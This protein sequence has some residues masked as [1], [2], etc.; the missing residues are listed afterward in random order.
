[1]TLKS[2]KK[3]S[4]RN[5]SIEKFT[6]SVVAG[7]KRAGVTPLKAKIQT[8]YDQGLTVRDTIALMTPKKVTRKA[9]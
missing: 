4:T 3:V 6:Q 2:A 7:C 5:W 9:A 8:A 1:M